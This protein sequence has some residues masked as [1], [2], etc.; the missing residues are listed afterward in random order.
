MTL[1]ESFN[2]VKKRGQYYINLVNDI[3]TIDEL[4]SYNSLKAYKKLDLK[5]L[6]LR[7]EKLVLNSDLGEKITKLTA[8]GVREILIF[9]HQESS[10]L[11]TDKVKKFLKDNN[12]IINFKVAQLRKSDLEAIKQDPMGSRDILGV[13]ELH[14]NKIT[15]RYGH[16]VKFLHDAQS[17][18][19]ILDNDIKHKI[20][21]ASQNPLSIADPN[22]IKNHKDAEKDNFSKNDIELEVTVDVDIEVEHEQQI[23]FDFEIEEDIEEDKEI[24][25]DDA[26]LYNKYDRRGAIDEA[27]LRLRIIFQETDLISNEDISYKGSVI[28]NKLFDSDPRINYISGEG[29]NLVL[30]YHDS[31][32]EGIDTNNLP[33]G[34][35]FN[36]RGIIFA[37]DQR[38]N[39]MPINSYTVKFDGVKAPIKEI[40]TY[41]WLPY[42]AKASLTLDDIYDK[43]FNLRPHA[44]FIPGYRAHPYL[45][46]SGAIDKRLDITY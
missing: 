42:A 17:D 26:Q 34:L 2:S 20:K 25:I 13:E 15:Y 38:I 29:L 33:I 44:V 3:Y 21:I 10:W 14:G 12:I 1:E 19:I 37:S 27:R 11:D 24:S 22:Y 30:K 18:E 46:W 7:V 16:E 43:N 32:E 40:L 35:A 8:N 9:C 45:T 36:N 5:S 6:Y 28:I 31:F 23:E 39:S 41:S 4:F